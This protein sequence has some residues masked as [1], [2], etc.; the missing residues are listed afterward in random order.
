M[1]NTYTKEDYAKSYAELIEILKYIPPNDL[2][3]I[4]KEKI[5]YYMQKQDNTHHFIYNTQKQFNEQNISHLTKILIANLYIEYWTNQE[6][7]EQIAE[8]DKKELYDLEL[9]KKEQYA[10]ENLFKNKIKQKEEIKTNSMI[11]VRKKNLIEKVIAKIKK[12]F[13][14]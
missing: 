6:E 4:P 3:K 1:I 5:N 12:Y 10:T 8:A 9:R 13:K 14:L 7:K 11:V 2:N